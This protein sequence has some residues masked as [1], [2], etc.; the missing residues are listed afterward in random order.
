M[1]ATSTQ[2]DW[3]EFF[4]L[5]R[6]LFTKEEVEIVPTDK[7]FS[8]YLVNRYISFYHPNMLVFVANTINDTKKFLQSESSA[9]HYKTLKAI[10]PK[11]PYYKIPYIKKPVSNKLKFNEDTNNDVRRLARYME[12]S[13]REVLNYI[14]ELN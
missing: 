11:L 14:A 13:Q 2:R 12:I 8:P 6:S 4:T 7:N 5:L 1:A 10:L 3:N 9:I